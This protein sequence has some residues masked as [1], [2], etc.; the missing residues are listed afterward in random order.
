MIHN[1]KWKLTLT[2]NVEVTDD[3]LRVLQDNLLLAFKS[4][5]KIECINSTIPL[6]KNSYMMISLRNNAISFDKQ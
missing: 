4:L 6:K 5:I 2:H 3:W 1:L